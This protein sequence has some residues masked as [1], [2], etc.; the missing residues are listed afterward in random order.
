MAFLKYFTAALFLFMLPAVLLADRVMLRSGEQID[1]EIVNQTRSELRI[2][3]PGGFRTIQKSDIRRVIF[4]DPE[5]EARI[6]REEEEKRKAEERLAE[7]K[8]LDE[9]RA[10]EEARLRRIEEERKQEADRVAEE[11]R[12]QEEEKKAQEARLENER[13]QEEARRKAEEEKT[14]AL[15]RQRAEEERLKKEEEQ[16]KQQEN[17]RPQEQKPSQEVPANYRYRMSAIGRSLILPGWGQ[18]YQGRTAAGWGYSASFLAAAGA[19][20]YFQDAYT[21]AKS[22]YAS[23]VRTSVLLSPNSPL[24]NGNISS[25]DTL[26]LLTLTSPTASADHAKYLA[27]RSNLAAAGSVVLG[28]YAL[29]LIDVIAFHPAQPPL[30]EKP[31]PVSERRDAK[32]YRSSAFL[33]SLILPGWGQLYMDRRA[34]GISYM[35]G[36]AALLSFYSAAAAQ[37]AGARADYKAA[38][39]LSVLTSPYGASIF[40]FIPAATGDAATGLFLLNNG[41][42]TNSRQSMAAAAHRTQFAAGALAALYLWNLADVLLFSPSDT[43]AVSFFA[44]PGAASFRFSVFF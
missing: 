19:A 16:R 24:F 26:T 41:T 37:Y 7:Q 6:K 5:E 8:R 20:A 40:P 36:S 39:N 28:I 2:R 9:E 30:P 34:P 32:K 13:I 1:G 33:R 11:K 22:H 44:A 14:A 18:F 25:D 15:V 29:N 31:T 3:G 12:R 17:P 4:S 23:S 38:V 42:L 35:A 43:T 10:R 21:S 27:A